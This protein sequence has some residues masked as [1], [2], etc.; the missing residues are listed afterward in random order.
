MA[1]SKKQVG[2]R[3]GK[4]LSSL[5]SFL[6]ILCDLMILNLLWLVCSLPVV[7]VGP[8][9]SALCRASLKLARGEQFSTLETWF[10]AFRRDFLQAL[11]LGL[12]GVVGLVIAGVDFWFAVAQTGTLRTVYLVVA[13]IVSALVLSYW[14]WVFALHASYENTLG[15]TIKNALSLAF[16]EPVKTVLIWIGFAVPVVC[17]LFLPEE[18]VIYLG[19][20]YIL[21]AVSAPAY[22]A[23]R[24]QIKVFDR[25]DESGTEQQAE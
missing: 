4:L 3:S 9:S 18:A 25:F 8:A 21:F 16:V 23:A 13:V 6:R 22:F 7:T 20:A 14:S 10:T 5:G 24:S 1:E 15:A 19:W 12:I 17:F 2:S 11:V